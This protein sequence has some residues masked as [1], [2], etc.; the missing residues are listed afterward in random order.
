VL[1]RTR[2]FF[3]RGRYGDAQ[4]GQQ[5]QPRRRIDGER[6]RVHPEDYQPFQEHGDQIQAQRGIRRGD[7]RW[8]KSEEHLYLG[9][10]Q[11]RADT[12]RPEGD[13]DRERV[14]T[15]GDE[16]GKRVSLT[17]SD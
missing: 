11:A 7:R 3:S 16:G 2:A 10:Q 9:G 15:H 12:E 13:D 4:N 8:Q 5:R 1:T 17:W 14:H 6:R